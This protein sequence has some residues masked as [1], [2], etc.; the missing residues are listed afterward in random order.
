METIAKD[1]R[2]LVNALKSTTAP[3]PITQ[4]QPQ[5]IAP[6]PREIRKIEDV[7]M[8]FPSELEDLLAFEEEEGYI[9]VKPRQYL[10]GENFAK[11]ASI[12]RGA[13]GEYISAGKDSHFRIP[14]KPHQ[15]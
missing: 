14:K 13:G 4:P 6:S 3:Q 8:M 2:E 5:P 15:D 12:V 10:G 7:R 9:I 11:I 1:L